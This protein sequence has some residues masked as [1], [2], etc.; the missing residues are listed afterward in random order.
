MPPNYNPPPLRPAAGVTLRLVQG[1][2]YSD[3]GPVIELTTASDGTFMA[4]TPA[5]RWCIARAR[6]AKPTTAHDMDTDLAC[7]VTNWETCDAVVDV[8]VKTPVMID[9]HEP[10]TWTVCYHGPPP[11]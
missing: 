6:G 2:K 11:P 7:L 10:C 8:P 1:D 5:G 4:P 9:I 3:A